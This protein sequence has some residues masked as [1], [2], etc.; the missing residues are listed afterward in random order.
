MKILKLRP[1]TLGFSINAIHYF[2][3]G[4]GRTA[5]ISYALLSR[6]YDGSIED[7]EYY[8]ALLENTKGR[9]VVN[10][11][12]A[13]SGVDERI[14]SEMFQ[15]IKEKSGFADAYGD[16]FPTYVYGGYPNVMAGEYSPAEIAVNDE[17]DET[18]RHML[19]QAMESGGMTMISIMATFGPDRVKDYV[20]TSSD[21]ERTVIDGDRFL[22]SLTQDEIKQWWINSEWAIASYVKRLINVS[23][24]GDIAEIA[25]HYKPHH[26][27]E[28]A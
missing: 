21:G 28:A 6:G 8:S 15:S 7:K 16:N 20:K 9:E 18:G 4:N 11:N 23:E 24:R 22:P 10:P 19:Y 12:P 14:R 27:L 26:G 25:A 13:V 3:D 1:L 17:I 2:A 5:R